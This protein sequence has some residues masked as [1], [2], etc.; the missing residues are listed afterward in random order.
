MAEVL[1]A[2]EVLY[3]R[4]RIWFWAMLVGL[5][6][7]L[8]A[9]YFSL[10]PASVHVWRQS[11]TMAVARNFYEED[12][13]IL[14]PRV[15]RRGATDGVTGMQFP[16]YEWLVAGAYSIF[17]F[18]E[19][20]PRLLNWL[21]YM[22]GV[23]A[24]YHLARQVSGAKHLGFVGAWCLAWSPEMYYHGI[25]AL[26][27]ILALTCSVAGLLWF[28]R[29]RE[30]PRPSLLLL[31]LLAVTLGGLTKLQYLAVGFPITV[32][33]GRDALTRRYSAGQLGQLAAY[34]GLAV[35]LPLAWYTYALRLIETSGLTSFGLELRPAAD[36]AT[37]LKIIKRN[38]LSDW[39]E[40]L[41]GYGSLGL[42]L[43]GLG[44]LVRR[45]PVAHPWF[46]P[47]LVWAA[48]LAAYYLIELH[49]MR[50][51]TYYM[52]PL[53]PLLLLLAAWG[54]AWLQT[55]ARISVYLL[56]SLLAI[57]PL[58][59]LARVNWGRWMQ[60]PDVPTELFASASR[61][62]LSAAIPDS[63]LCVVGPDYTGCVYLYF[64]HKKGFVFEDP[65][66]L[67]APQL[68]A[69]QRQGAR[70]LYTSDSTLIQQ[71][72]LLPYL[73]QEVRRVGSFRVLELRPVP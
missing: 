50:G 63:A 73:G 9:P 35:G 25:N 6:F 56:I 54:A 33:V 29:W 32:F 14:R 37:G 49:Q 60:P 53:L 36:L 20:L 70:Y 39:P 45:P 18:H 15:N 3:S 57:Q 22:A 51:H 31:S 10:P 43:L 12:M 46:V 17:G 61:I 34:A 21:I 72:T 26:P 27:D 69:F 1:S 7:L 28:V 4:F 5:N 71:P 19:A 47:G 62:A 44:R 40:L 8:H 68:A 66:L 16:A 67:T 58:W 23:V 65:A 64:L 24:F 38:L 2:P 42:L 55:S 11:D 41:L 13:N 59:A 48:G 52:L 30:T